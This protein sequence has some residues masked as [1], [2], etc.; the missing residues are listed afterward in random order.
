MSEALLADVCIGIKVTFRLWA[1]PQFPGIWENILCVFSYQICIYWT[2]SFQLIFLVVVLE[3]IIVILKTI[4]YHSQRKSL[5][6][7]ISGIRTFEKCLRNDVEKEIEFI[8]KYIWWSCDMGR[9]WQI[10]STCRGD[11]NRRL[12]WFDDGGLWGIQSNW[13][14]LV[15]IWLRRGET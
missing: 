15:C 12:Q 14:F 1:A 13:G 10:W 7:E 6:R 8:L 4:K 5:C 9:V 3:P 11:S 2:E